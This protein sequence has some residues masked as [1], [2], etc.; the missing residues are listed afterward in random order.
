M[1]RYLGPTFGMIGIACRNHVSCDSNYDDCGDAGM[2]DSARVVFL[3]N[4]LRGDDVSQ[5]DEIDP[6]D[7]DGDHD[8]RHLQKSD[9]S[10]QQCTV[11]WSKFRVKF[12]PSALLKRNQQNCTELLYLRAIRDKR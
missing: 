1:F 5:L 4:F 2:V 8:R 9:P 10:V 7:R 12:N 6:S 11:R 3:R